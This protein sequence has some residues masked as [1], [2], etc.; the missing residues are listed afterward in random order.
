MTTGNATST[1]TR[2]NVK[3][4]HLLEVDRYKIFKRIASR[5]YRSLQEFCE[6]ANLNLKTVES[7]MRRDETRVRAQTLTEIASALG[8]G[9][10]ELLRGPSVVGTVQRLWS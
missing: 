1:R 5:G 7:L 8:C 10:D 9:P 2:T 3:R 6:C 4:G